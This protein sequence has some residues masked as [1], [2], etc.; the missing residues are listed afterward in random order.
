MLQGRHPEGQKR[1]APWVGQ[2]TSGVLNDPEVFQTT[3]RVRPECVQQG[4]Y[5]HIP[6][7]PT[8]I[9][10]FRAVHSEGHKP[11]SEDLADRSETRMYGFRPKRYPAQGLRSKYKLVMVEDRMSPNA[12]DPWYVPRHKCEGACVLFD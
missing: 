4:W 10:Y 12:G 3:E 9:L 1:E 11:P 8:T 5:A 2:T 6:K 7:P